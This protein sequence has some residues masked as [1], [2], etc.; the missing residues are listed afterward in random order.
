M[1]VMQRGFDDR[2]D[3]DG[4]RLAQEHFFFRAACRVVAIEE[5][6]DV[7]VVIDVVAELGTADQVGQ[8]AESAAAPRVSQHR[9]GESLYETWKIRWSPKSLICW[10]RLFIS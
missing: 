2:Y 3:H 9:A 7:E 6:E 1:E 5:R 8:S 4:D 10:Y